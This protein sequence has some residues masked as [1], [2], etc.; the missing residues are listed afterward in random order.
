MWFVF[1]LV[2]VVYY[3]S[4]KSHLSHAL[5]SSMRLIR[6]AFSFSLYLLV[7]NVLPLATSLGESFNLS[8]GGYCN[9]QQ[10]SQAYCL[11]LQNL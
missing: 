7:S 6:A 4:V 5:F 2:F 1:I 3:F 8:E 11:F 9:R 10:M